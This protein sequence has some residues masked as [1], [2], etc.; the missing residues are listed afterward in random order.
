MTD[1]RFRGTH[2]L[3]AIEDWQVPDN[4]SAMEEITW[5][6][7]D[8]EIAVMQAYNTDAFKKTSIRSW[9]CICWKNSRNYPRSII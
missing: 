7:E 9:V 3:N 5:K 4:P 6:K 2:S 1:S 8:G